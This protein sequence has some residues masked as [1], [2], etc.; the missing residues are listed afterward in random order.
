[1]WNALY[2]S[3]LRRFVF[4][5][6][7]TFCMKPLQG[8]TLERL[9]LD[10]MIAKSTAI[11]RGKV[12]SSFGR[13]HGPVIYT[14]FRLQVAETYKGSAVTDVMV[15]GGT[16]GGTTQ[17]VAGAAQL[18]PG[19]EYVLFLWTGPSGATQILGLT[20]GVFAV[21]EDAADDPTLVRSASTELMLDPQTAQAVKD[22][23]L[24]M[25]LSELKS[26]IAGA[27]KPLPV[28]AKE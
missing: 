28:V 16:A 13:F 6:V 11:V 9:S 17:E 27:P 2:S 14:H 8:T 26:R 5:L 23:R 10:G 25:R 1:M 18:T 22:Q 24:T 19:R 20:Q 3:V 4:A 7:L 15:P 21:P 12:L